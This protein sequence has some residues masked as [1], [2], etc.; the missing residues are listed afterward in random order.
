VELKVKEQRA[1]WNWRHAHPDHDHE[2]R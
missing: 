2:G 1:Y